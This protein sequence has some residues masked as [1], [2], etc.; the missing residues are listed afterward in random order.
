[1]YSSASKNKYENDQLNQRKPFSSL[2][3]QSMK[4]NQIENNKQ[5]EQ[6]NKDPKENKNNQ[7]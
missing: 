2:N 6:L 1:M 3:E 7:Q 4:E 5:K